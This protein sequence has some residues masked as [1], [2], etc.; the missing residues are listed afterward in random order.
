MGKWLAVKGRVLC[1]TVY[2]DM[3]YKDLLGSIVNVE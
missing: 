2:G 3:H 1:G